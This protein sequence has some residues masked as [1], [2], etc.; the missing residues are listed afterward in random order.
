MKDDRVSLTPQQQAFVDFQEGC[1]LLHAPV[2]TGKTRALAER[3]AQAIRRGVSPERIL[4]VTFTNRAAEEM[5]QRVA[6]H[7][8]AEA[9]WV[10]VR[11][12]H[13]LCAWML[14]RE[15]KE[16]GLP[17][18]FVIFDEEDSKEILREVAPEQ[19]ARSLYHYICSLKVEVDDE[20][21]VVG[22]IPEVLLA[23]GRNCKREILAYQEELRA[24]HALD[25]ADLILQTRVMLMKHPQIRAR[26]QGKFDMIQVDEMQDTHLSEYGVLRILA[27]GCGN[28]VLAGDFDQTIY[29]W[30]GSNPGEILGRFQQDFPG[31]RAFSFDENHRATRSLVVAA[32]KVAASFSRHAPPRPSVK[33]SPGRPIEVHFART[34]LEEADWIACRLKTELEASPNLQIGVLTRSNH[35]ALAIAQALA[36]MEV[37]HLTVETYEFFR[38]QE[39]KDAI[40]YIRFLLNPWDGRSFRRILSRPRR[41]IGERTIAKI[42]GAHQTG[43]R[44]VDLAQPA[45]LLGD[46]F[47]LLMNAFRYGELIILDVETT[48]LDPSRDEVIELAALRLVKGQEAECFHRYLRNTKSV[49]DSVAIHGLTDE[50]LKAE[51]E[52]PATVLAELEAFCQDAPVVGHNISF[53]L[54]MLRAFGRRLGVALDLG[55]NMDTLEIARRFLDLDDYRLEYLKQHLGLADLPSHRAMDDVRTTRALLE[56]L[57]PLVEKDSSA[58]RTVVG[59]AAPLFAPVV[60][61][62]ESLRTKVDSLR[63]WQLLDA[64]LERSGLAAFYSKEPHRTAN[65][66]ELRNIFKDRDEAD[67]DPRSSLEG[68]MSFAALARNVD[69]LDEEDNRVKVLTVHQA[70]GLEF[71]LVVIAGLAE[72]EFPNYGACKEG[73]EL[74]ERRVFY[75]A[76]TRAKEHLILT[77]HGSHDGK[78]RLPSRYFRL[79][80]DD[81][82]ERDSYR[83]AKYQRR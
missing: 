6:L 42:D 58:R 50:F 24:N 46:P 57:I 36:R 10:E 4:C 68:I 40:A 34:S 18:D 80:G 2:G 8:Q 20:Q 60:A 37:P 33:A 74:E 12:F 30:R 43:L 27:K 52:D 25:F 72:N 15:A 76:V 47:A 9:R 35:R 71:D 16:I 64:V 39:V 31:V 73:R 22:P 41:G 29:E 51:G 61:E 19:G 78:V 49:G 45:T 26:W 55:E 32:A 82:E 21:L 81:W 65:L 59:S 14:R 56:H 67:K 79:I 13:G 69:R 54:R 23:K 3:T 5:R 70:K 53:D 83:F 7:C 17:T 77:G 11:T 62:V 63:P 38:R 28:L 44:L 66:A 48:G 1:A 75:V